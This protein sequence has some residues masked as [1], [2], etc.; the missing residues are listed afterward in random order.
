M[1]QPASQ[2]RAAFEKLC[3][4]RAVF[5]GWQ[6]GTRTA[7]DPESQAVR[8]HREVTICL[9]AE[10]NALT[11]IM[12]KKGVCTQEELQAQMIEEAI[13][14]DVQYERKFPGFTSA[15]YGMVMSMPDVANTMK[16]WRP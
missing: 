4:W 8:D 3:K 10:V 16:G 15:E 5:A 14:L 1:N 13:A 12:L 9:R 2:L 11:S 6:L 7:D